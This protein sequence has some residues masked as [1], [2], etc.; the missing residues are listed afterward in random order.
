MGSP[1]FLNV[2]ATNIG[3]RTRKPYLFGYCRERLEFWL[4]PN[5]GCKRLTMFVDRECV[6]IYIGG[7]GKL[8][9]AGVQF[10]RVKRPAD[11][12]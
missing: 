3:M 5:G 7:G 2:A 6:Q 4:T 8:H 1:S 10:S 11:P 9:I 12:M